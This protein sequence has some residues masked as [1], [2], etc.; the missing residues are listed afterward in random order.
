MN[1]LSQ[2]L[3]M[4]RLQEWEALGYGM[5]I[6]FG[7]STFD[8][9]EY[10]LGNKPSDFYA[11]DKLNVDEWISVAKEAGMKYAILTTKHVSG[12]CLWPSKYT[13][14]HVGTSANKTDVVA[15][16]VKACN[17][18]GIMPGFYYCS[19]DNHHLFGSL[20]P[21]LTQWDYAY[22]TEEYQEFQ[23]NQITE[24]LTQY[25]KIGEVWIDIP[26]VLPRSYRIKLYN[27]IAKLQPDAVIMMNNGLS[28][29][30][31]LSVPNTWPSDIV[32]IERWLPN[33]FDG[34]KKVRE[35]EGK[36]YYL[37]GEVNDPIGKEW[38][39][40]EGDNPRSDEE[41][42]GMYLVARARNTNFLLDVPPNKEGLIPE[43]SVEALLRLK[44]NIEK[45]K[46]F[47]K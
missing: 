1:I 24:L 19:W 39:Y 38:F 11:P 15:E 10:N 36:T 44:E 46:A 47:Q 6:H 12:H 27:H 8:P 29:G 5:F 17:K 4:E 40:V 34:H 42:L 31:E 35:I 30:T 41:L 26:K 16:F 23:T 9:V 32:A 3:S 2:R 14:Y 33:S 37:P 13:E 18:Y 28:D 43:S 7:M 20:T 22:T 45:L 21:S 25:G